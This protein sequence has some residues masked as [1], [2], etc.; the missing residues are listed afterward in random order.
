MTSDL[1]RMNK[2]DTLCYAIEFNSLQKNMPHPAHVTQIGDDVGFGNG[3]SPA[4]DVVYIL[5]QEPRRL[6]A[7]G[8]P[9]HQMDQRGP[10]Y[11]YGR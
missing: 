3:L 11:R 7:D 9:L 8:Q 5:T 4:E 2:K 1:L 6:Q 10:C